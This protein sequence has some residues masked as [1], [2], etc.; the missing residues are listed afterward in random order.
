MIFQAAPPKYTLAQVCAA[1][2]FFP[3]YGWDV[4]ASCNGNTWFCCSIETVAPAVGDIRTKTHLMTMP[5]IK[6]THHPAA[7]KCALNSNF[8]VTIPRAEAAGHR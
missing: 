3:G 5:F 4:S 7:L 2:G 1:F 6:H 8:C